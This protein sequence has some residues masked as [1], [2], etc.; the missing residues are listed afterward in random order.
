MP[1]VK[2]GFER[3]DLL[4]QPFSQFASS[5]YRYAGNIV[6]GL[7]G[8]QLGTLATGVRKDVDQVRCYLLQTQLKNLK[9]TH[10]ARAHDDRIGFNDGR[11][12]GLL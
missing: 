4:K 3:C 9:Q 11:S 8:V 12:H 5:A 2:M 10:R 1:Q 6:D 7:I